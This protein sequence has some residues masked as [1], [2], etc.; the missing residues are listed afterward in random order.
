MVCTLKNELL[1]FFKFVLSCF[2]LGFVFCEKHSARAKVADK[3]FQP[4]RTEYYDVAFMGRVQSR[5][6]QKWLVK[7]HIAGRKIEMEV[8]EDFY[9]LTKKGNT[10]LVAY[11]ESWIDQNDI[12]VKV[13]G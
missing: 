9:K 6:K 7:I 1:D 2:G 11:K 10:I 13:L 8:S 4:G 5:I 12:K 3:R